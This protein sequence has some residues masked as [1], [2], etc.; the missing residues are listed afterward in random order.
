MAVLRESSEQML[1]LSSLEFSR[2]VDEKKWSRNFDGF[3]SAAGECEVGAFCFTG[4][5]LERCRLTDVRSVNFYHF[6]RD[7]FFFFVALNC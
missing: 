3:Q 1:V 4:G 5:R 7:Y 2:M 6:A